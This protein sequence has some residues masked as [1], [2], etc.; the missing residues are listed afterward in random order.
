MSAGRVL[1]RGDDAGVQVAGGC[2]I[3]RGASIHRRRP[4]A[5]APHA[6]DGSWR[7]AAGPPTVRPK[8]GERGKQ[9]G[10]TISLTVRSTDQLR[11]AVRSQMIRSS[12]RRRP[13]G[14]HGLAGGE[15]RLALPRELP[16]N[17][18]VATEA[19]L[20]LPILDGDFSCALPAGTLLSEDSVVSG[21]P[22]PNPWA[23]QVIVQVKVSRVVVAIESPRRRRVDTVVLVRVPVLQPGL[24]SSTA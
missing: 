2:V 12:L 8:E 15:Y 6:Y 10:C 18:P 20:G 13:A 17:D 1:A 21:D 4:A 3:G 19:K 22:L 5:S 9:R 16:A 24:V 11:A 14:H 7:D 23:D